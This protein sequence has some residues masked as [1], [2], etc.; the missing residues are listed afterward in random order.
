MNINNKTKEIKSNKL[1]Y[2]TSCSMY[3]FQYRP[4]LL[5]VHDVYKPATS[6]LYTLKGKAVFPLEDGLSMREM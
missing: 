2:M 6:L 4:E 1:W 5:H 3:I